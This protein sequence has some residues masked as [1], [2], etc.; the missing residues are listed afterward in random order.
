MHSCN[1]TG[2]ILQ[3]ALPTKDPYGHEQTGTRPCIFIA[4]PSTIQP[5]RFSMIII[6]PLTTKLFDPLPLY[7]RLAEGVGG[8]PAASTVL[9]D[10]LCAIDPSRVQGYVGELTEEEFSPIKQGLLL[11]FGLNK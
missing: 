4:D 3:I 8:L 1:N 9:L 10:Q 2:Q 6:A 5:L 11:M 7:P